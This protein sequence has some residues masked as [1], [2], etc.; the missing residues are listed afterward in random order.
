MGRPTLL[1]HLRPLWR[2]RT[3]LQLGTDPARAVVL[4]FIDP[5]AARMLELLD[6]TRTE[7]AL[8][9]EA[10]AA[11]VPAE[12][13]REILSTLREAGVLVEANA[14]FPRGLSEADR[15]RLY[16]EA[17]AL[18]L[19]GAANG[20]TP[21]AVL[22][23]R[24]AA[25]VLVTGRD[26]LAGPISAALRA[27]GVGHVWLTSADRIP[28]QEGHAPTLVVQL[29]SERRP[30]ALAARSYARR[31]L[32][33]LAVTTRDGAVVV[34]P[35]VPPS[36]SPCLRCLDLYRADRDPAWPALAAQLATGRA[37]PPACAATTA[38]AG[39]AYAAGE[40]LAYLD[41]RSPD[42]RGAT[43]E[44]TAPAQA[45]RRTWAP[46]P[47]CDCGRRRRPASPGAVL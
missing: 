8:L 2:D 13:A 41:G 12:R 1:P 6:G 30:A 25:G 16:A 4:E 23:R 22:R 18:A 38:L 33:L 11:G 37:G 19:F 26:P 32:P 42:T 7:T 47:G 35:L 14:L 9:A 39:A 27:A 40:A 46:H 29:G 31:G 21:A 15:H 10:S 43:V 44:I 3:T 28:A 24:A 45:R 5:A 36:G 20:R 17:A 34:G